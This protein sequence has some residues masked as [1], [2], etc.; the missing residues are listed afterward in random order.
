MGNENRAPTP[1]F[2]KV[3]GSFLNR[4]NQNSTFQGALVREMVGLMGLGLVLLVGCE[5]TPRLR[6]YE[7]EL[8]PEQIAEIAIPSDVRLISVGGKS[9][10]GVTDDDAEEKQRALAAS[11]PYDENGIYPRRYVQVP[12]GEQSLVIGL[13]KQMVPVKRE[14]HIAVALLTGDVTY[15][16]KMYP[17]STQNVILRFNARP[18]GK[19]AIAP[20]WQNDKGKPQ[21]WRFIVTDRKSESSDL[22]FDATKVVP[23]ESKGGTTMS[24]SDWAEKEAEAMKK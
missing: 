10:P 23:N 1:A 12:A 21:T 2:P 16:K 17:G 11:A 13:S 22:K 4:S 3:A 5:S 24:P 19:Y 8:K 20:R 14:T 7:G 18:G 6:A 9:F 15:S